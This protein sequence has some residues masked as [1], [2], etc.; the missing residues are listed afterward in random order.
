MTK[1]TNEAVVQKDSKA[2]DKSKN[3]LKKQARKR[4]E[5]R[6]I[7][8]EDGVVEISLDKVMTFPSAFSER[9]LVAVA[10]AGDNV[11][12]VRSFLSSQFSYSN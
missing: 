6:E 8:K 7:A 10:F 9:D 1:K 12:K 11:V 4:D 2:L 3:K 5:V